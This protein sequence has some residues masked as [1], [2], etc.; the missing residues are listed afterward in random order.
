MTARDGIREAVEQGEGALTEGVAQLR[1]SAEGAE[2]WLRERANRE[3]LLALGVAVAAGFVLGR[4]L[5]RRS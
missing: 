1:D 2:R 3:P 4:L 5:S